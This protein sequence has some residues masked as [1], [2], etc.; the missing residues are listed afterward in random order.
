MY[1]FKEIADPERSKDLRGFFSSTGEFYDSPVNKKLLVALQGMAERSLKGRQKAS[2]LISIIEMHKNKQSKHY[3]GK[4][5]MHMDI[6]CI[7]TKKES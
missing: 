4:I 1:K 5:L 3:L 6:A 2:L 7:G